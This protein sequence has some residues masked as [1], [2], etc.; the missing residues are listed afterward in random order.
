MIMSVRSILVYSAALNM[1][2]IM[3]VI[4]VK[5]NIAVIQSVPE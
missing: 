5:D 4:V 2:Y 3:K 1:Q